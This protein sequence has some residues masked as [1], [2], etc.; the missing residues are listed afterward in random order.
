MLWIGILTR[1][2]VSVNGAYMEITF[3]W[4]MPPEGDVHSGQEERDGRVGGVRISLHGSTG[5]GGQDP[6]KMAPRGQ[7][8]IRS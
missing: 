4:Q 6:L 2:F 7:K 1:Y 3:P 5:F 8:A